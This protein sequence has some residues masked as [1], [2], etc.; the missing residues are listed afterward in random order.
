LA[1]RSNAT[2][3]KSRQGK[4]ALHVT[5][6]LKG[7]LTDAQRDE[8]YRVADRCPLHK[9]MTT[10]EVTIETHAPQGFDSQ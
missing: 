9:L 4:Y 6:T 7:V 1:S 2:T 10:S 3:A 8:L 5:L